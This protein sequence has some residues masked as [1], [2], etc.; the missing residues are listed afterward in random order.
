M[1]AAVSLLLCIEIVLSF[2]L[3]CS[4]SFHHSAAGVVVYPCVRR[5]MLSASVLCGTAVLVLMEEKCIAP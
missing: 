5:A 1:L 3:V 4:R 2:S